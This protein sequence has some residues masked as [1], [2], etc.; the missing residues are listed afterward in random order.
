MP[1]RNRRSNNSNPSNNLSRGRNSAHKKTP[2]F[3][4]PLKPDYTVS[5]SARV[6]HT[7][8]ITEDDGTVVKESTQISKL[9]EDATPYQIL[10]FFR[11][12]QDACEIM[13][14]NTGALMFSKIKQHLQGIHKENCW[15]E[16]LSVVGSSRSKEN[17]VT[18]REQFL[19][20]TFEET[21]DY[22]VQ[23]DYLRS[24]K[25][26]PEMLVK[27]FLQYLK[28][29]NKQVQMIPG[30]PTVAGLSSAELK[31]TFLQAMPRQWQLNYKNAGKTYHSETLTA[32]RAY[33]DL[34]VL[35]LTLITCILMTWSQNTMR[36]RKTLKWNYQ[37]TL[38]PTLSL[39]PLQQLAR[40][41]TS[42]ETTF[43]R[44]SWIL[45]DLTS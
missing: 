24:I 13:E 44:L 16:A 18:A 45:V 17:F 43:S 22:D 2:G 12:F 35:L 7:K 23:I 32:M 36:S 14:W 27:T 30:A 10:D 26:P 20:N 1:N 4:I 38:L 39:S 5:D 31:K 41:V 3:V 6:K 28:V 37:P 40:S 34:H 8:E 42:L 29:A 19:S 25:K 15:E 21:R 11:K 33:F 9:P